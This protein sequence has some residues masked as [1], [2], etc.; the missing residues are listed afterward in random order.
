MKFVECPDIGRRALSEF[1]YGG[2]VKRLPK[3]NDVNDKAWTDY[4]FYRHSHPQQQL[5][6]WHHRP[7]GIW[8]WFERHTLMDQIVKV[9]VAASGVNHDG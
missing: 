6:W 1:T 5:E 8:F 3:T 4:L 7:T 2:V 9:T